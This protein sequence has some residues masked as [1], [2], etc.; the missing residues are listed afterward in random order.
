MTD[1]PRIPL[2]PPCRLSRSVLWRLQRRFFERRGLAAW[3]EGVVPHYV[4][5]NPYLARA[6]SRVVL[7]FVRDWH[8]HLGPSRPLHIIELGAGSGRLAFH[9]LRCFERLLAGSPF[10]DVP[11][12]YVMTDFAESTLAAWRAHPALGPW[13]DAGRLDFARFDAEHDATLVL[14]RA[15]TTLAPGNVEAP[16][17]AIANYV[18]DGLP[19][20]A[21]SVADGQLSEWLVSLCSDREEH[22]LDDPDILG[23][24]DL[25][26]EP[27]A[28]EPGPYYGDAALDRILEEHRAR[29]SGTAFTFPSASLACVGRLADLAGDRLLV[30]STDKGAVSEEA[31]RGHVGPSVTV[32]GSYSMAV[33]YHA[34]ARLASERGG[35]ALVPAERPHYVA[36]CAFLLGAPPGGYVETRLAYAEAIEAQSP[37]DFFSLKQS[38]DHVYE[39][40]T[41]EQLI[42]YLRFTDF[43]P[44]ILTQCLPALMPL[45]ST[46][47]AAERAELLRVLARAWEAYL[48]I[49]EAQDLPF[50]LGTLASAM[51]AWSE[52]VGFF[53]GSLRW[54]GRDPGTLFNLAMCHYRL[55]QRAEALARL[56]EVLALEPALEP[57]L[58]LRAH[59]AA[60]REPR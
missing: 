36:T 20:D 27:R 52:A 46:A 28:L 23:R 24:A 56:D 35:E 59:L 2:E 1:A 44:R 8:A 49:G 43:D 17:V 32:H 48:P 50:A 10:R 13:L 45:A 33:N 3:S 4:T 34:I 22:D 41:L 26:Y 51:D 47:T 19:L 53:E 16:V 11:F 30:L 57:A 58:A 15:G 54:Y 9:F 60:P 38:M 40:L 39:T 18:F 42:A 21:F 29:L 25:A 31:L 55:G 12:R 37:D 5:S 6:Y 7:G 14:E